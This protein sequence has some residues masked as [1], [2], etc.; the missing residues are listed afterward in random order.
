MATTAF[1]NTYLSYTRLKRFEECPKAFELYYVRKE[2]SEPNQN[3]LFGGLIHRV[4]EE[5]VRSRWQARYRG[6]IE[7]ADLREILKVRWQ[8]AGLSSIEQF[9][10]GAAILRDFVEKNPFFDHS[11]ILGVETEFA[12]EV[13]PFTVKGY[14][15][16]ID[17]LEDGGVEVIDYKTSRMIFSEEEVAHDLQ[18]SIYA[19]AVRALF[20]DVRDVRLSLYLLRHGFKMTTTRTEEQLAVACDYIETLGRQTEEATSFPARLNPNC[21]HC[22]HRRQCPAYARALLGEHEEIPEDLDKLERIAREREQVAN[23]AK[24]AYARKAELEGVLKAHL[25]DRDE[26]VLGGVRYWMGETTRLDYPRDPTLTILAEATG[27]E[28]AAL[29]ER[30]LVIDKARVDELLKALREQMAPAQ[31][32]L[33]QTRLE[34]VAEK[35]ASPRFNA[36][37]VAAR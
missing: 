35:A 11:R 26:L 27:Q 6:P 37:K 29:A 18:L 14:I 5:Y 34:A 15:D 1:K 33:L 20:P 32:R 2:P 10:E 4:L 21:V 19:L 22:D 31:V 24:I 12:I 30:L 25:R 16:R 9:E 36:Q 8:E 13:G 23:V 3:V 28:P 17:R 7:L